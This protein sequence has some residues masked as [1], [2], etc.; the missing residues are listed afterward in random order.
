MCLACQGG[1]P[2]DSIEALCPYGLKQRTALQMKR[3]A[4]LL[5]FLALWAQF[6]DVLLPSV[7]AFQ[8][9][10]LSSDDDEFVL[11]RGQEE[12][13]WL[14]LR[15][16]RQSASVKPKGADFSFVERGLA[17]ELNLG[18]RLVPPLLYVFMSLQ[19]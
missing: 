9:T 5:I 11:S 10:P 16:Q 12:Q 8:S 1:R 7:S 14:G 19:I 2:A 6:D 4:Y 17:T 18:T 13:R 3:I 15:R